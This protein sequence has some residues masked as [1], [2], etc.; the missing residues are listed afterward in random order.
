MGLTL[1]A[2]LA[3]GYG[4]G[5]LSSVPAFILAA[6]ALSLLAMVVGLGTEKLS[7]R[8]NPGAT[9]VIQSTLGNLPELLVCIF[10]LR[11]GLVEVVKGALVGSILAN[12]VL[13]LGIA[14]LVGGLK[15]G[16]QRFRSE[17][18]R[19]IAI[20][21][22]LAA[23][24]LAIPTMAHEL[25]TAADKHVSALS[26]VCAVVLLVLYLSSLSFFMK[27]DPEIAADT[28]ESEADAH[29]PEWPLATSVAVLA[30]AAVAAAFVSEWF[31]AALEPAT[32]AMGLSEAFTGLVVVAIAGNAIENFV[33]IQLALKNKMD[34]SVSVILN[35]SLQIALLLV[36]LLVMISFFVGNTPLTLVLNPMLLATLL[37]SSL[38]PIFII[39]DGESIWLEGASL[40]GLYILIA[41]A[42]WWG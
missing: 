19:M 36:P 35:S 39:S 41:A 15:H 27:G 18:P 14:F 13:V 24:A 22:I 33:G 20:M 2:T 42:F 28:D 12:S 23:C 21:M 4:H 38:L 25:H 40:I 37:M 9:G 11:A 29:G 34:L 7:T 8:L 3:A 16:T 1:V 32:K 10:S 6:A 31:V 17:P 30:I 26:M 5:G